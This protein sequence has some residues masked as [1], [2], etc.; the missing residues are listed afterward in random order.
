VADTLECKA[1]ALRCHRSQ[2]SDP[3]RVMEFARER[4]RRAGEEHG[5]EYAETFRKISLRR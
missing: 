5:V 4:L 2:F 1:E 3:E